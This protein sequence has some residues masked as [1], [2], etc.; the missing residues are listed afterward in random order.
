MITLTAKI[1]I[2]KGGALSGVSDLQG[3]NI[4]SSIPLG[5]K[6]SVKNPFIIGASRV[7]DG[8]TISGKLDYFIGSQ[9]S[10]EFGIFPYPYS[11]EVFGSGISSITIAFDTENNRHPKEIIVDGTLSIY[12]DDAI[13]TIVG[14]DPTKE[15]HTFYI[16]SW[17][18]PKYPLVISGIYAGAFID[19]N[20]RNLISL[21]FGIV[22]KEADGLPSYG[23]ISSGSGK[24][25]IKDVDGEIYDFAN[26]KLLGDNIYCEI[27]L[28][29]TIS[30]SKSTV[31]KKIASKWEY[32]IQERV[33]YC[34]LI[35]DMERMQDIEFEVGYF[36]QD[37]TT[38]LDKVMDILLEKASS[39]GFKIEV[40]SKCR[41]ILNQTVTEY[42]HI[43]KGSL[44]S[45]FEKICSLCGFYM[46]SSFENGENIIKIV[47][48]GEF[49]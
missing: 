32:D 19:V 39:E 7:G 17:N 2:I 24:L 31:S 29:D 26:N 8:S 20:K 18:D 10:N 28:N 42:A 14:L 13:Y 3:N 21:N 47:S 27:Y 4:S 34:N 22:K 48:E 23:V 43:D 9:L 30:K 16:S 44:W 40:S 1:D 5:S 6:K 37:K 36:E 15:N 45:C 33:A 41:E 35:D 46:Y 38:T 49:N 11:I 25:K 12:D